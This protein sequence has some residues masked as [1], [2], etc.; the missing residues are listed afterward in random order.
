MIL[1]IKINT[2]S[3]QTDHNLIPSRKTNALSH[4]IL[5]LIYIRIHDRIIA[6]QI[7]S[8]PNIASTQ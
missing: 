6:N 1:L 8:M 4:I 3:F 7:P 2:V 5:T